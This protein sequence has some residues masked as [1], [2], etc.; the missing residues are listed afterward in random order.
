MAPAT[1]RPA[2]SPTQIPATWMACLNPQSRYQVTNVLADQSYGTIKFDTGPVRNTVVT[3]A[4]IARETVSLDTYTGLTSEAIG[5]DANATGGIGP[6]SIL[7]PPNSLPFGT[8]TVTGN[9][10]FIP[11]N[12]KSLFALE[13]A[14]YRDFVI[15][16][17]G[18][19]FDNYEISASK[20]GTP[21]VTAVSNMW[22]YN[23]GLVV[24]P[25]PIASVYAAYGTSSE[26]VG[27]ELDGTSANYGGLNPTASTTVNQIFQRRCRPKRRK[28]EPSGSCWTA[29]CWRPARCFAPTSAMPANRFRPACQTPAQSRPGPPTMSRASTSARPAS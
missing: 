18:L 26:P 24:K 15:F 17:A 9:P 5:A 11:V 20:T 22:N 13:T 6:V 16:T 10:T 29:I 14:N 19:R 21:T 7:N 1:P 28:S 8:P 2:T 27:A 3:G 25:M 4:E 12:S 23:L